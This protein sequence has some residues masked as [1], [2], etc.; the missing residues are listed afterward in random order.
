MKA[1]AGRPEDIADILALA[2][3]L[4]LTHAGEVLALVDRYVPQRLVA[5]RVQYLIETLFPAEGPRHAGA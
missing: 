2:A 5:P 4:Q 1:I 3:H